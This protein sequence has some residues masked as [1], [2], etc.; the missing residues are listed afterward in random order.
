MGC[1]N[2]PASLSMEHQADNTL[3]HILT[4]VISILGNHTWPVL[5]TYVRAEYR[6]SCHSQRLLE[7][8]DKYHHVIRVL[9][10]IWSRHGRGIL[11]LLHDS[12]AW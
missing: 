10:I 5:C 6:M 8:A 7:S 11:T 3:A 12:F 1:T 9:E 4:Y 2:R